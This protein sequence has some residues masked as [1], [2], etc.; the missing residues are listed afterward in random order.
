MKKKYYFHPSSF[1]LSE[2]EGFY[3]EKARKGLFLEKRNDYLSRFRVDEPKDLLYRVEVVD[4]NK[5]E[6]RK[7]S[8][9]QVAVYED[10]GWTYVCGNGY[11]H[12][13]SAD[14]EADVPELYYNPEDQI[15]TVKILRKSNIRGMISILVTWLLLSLISQSSYS[16]MNL[17]EHIQ[18]LS[19]DVYIMI[20][21]TPAIFMGISLIVVHTI[22]ELIFGI[23][24]SQYHIVKLKKG[25]PLRKI[26]P[27]ARKLK[28]GL[29]SMLIVSIAAILIMGIMEISSLRKD[30][31]PSAFN[32]PYLTLEDF[33][34]EKADASKDLYYL[35]DSY[36]RKETIWGEVIK[37]VEYS[38][39]FY[40]STS[41][42]QDV[43]QVKNKKMRSE[44]VKAFSTSD[45]FGLFTY[46]SEK[47]IVDGLDEVYIVGEWEMVIV[48]DDIVMRILYH[49][50]DKV[51]QEEILVK[52]SEI[53]SRRELSLEK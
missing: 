29:K 25:I 17:Q 51:S 8:E 36:K 53:L 45:Y 1:S 23:S 52:I 11:I 41:L 10:C 35:E 20:I 44:L 18:K 4:Y 32:G 37:T 27:F 33:G 21:D 9:A 49:L 42:Y 3:E 38:N 28:L 7:I 34:I 2:I 6:N 48:K 43:Y 19:N 14:K 40:N 16:R 22:G 13:F 15:E 24:S 46:D 47:I 31:D 5:E 30:Q 39:T 12:V 50:D 26:K